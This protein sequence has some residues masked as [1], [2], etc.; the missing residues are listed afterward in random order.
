MDNRFKFFT[1]MVF[2]KNVFKTVFRKQNFIIPKPVNGVYVGASKQFKISKD[3]LNEWNELLNS[4]GNSKVIPYTYYWP[5]LM[6]WLMKKLLPELG[7]NLR[8]VLHTGQEAE[9]PQNF[10]NVVKESNVVKLKL[11]DLYPLKRNK[12]DMVTLTVV[13][14]KDG[15]VLFRAIDHTIILNMKNSDMEALK[16]SDIWGKVDVPFKN[17]SF[18]NKESKFSDSKN[19]GISEFYCKKNI[20][21]KFG[22]VS[23]ALSVTHATIL[24]AKIFRQGKV[25]LQGMCTGNIV[26]RALFHQLKEDVS[27]FEVYFTNQ[28]PFPQTV[29]VRFDETDF[30]VFDESNTMV[31]YGTRKVHQISGSIE[32]KEQKVA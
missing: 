18:R 6:D 25:F 19:C 3:Y 21:S 2:N 30:E 23:G 4:E 8:N 16:K 13:E 17:N 5:W 15:E 31:A 9:F 20:A 1:S 22:S 32:T 27:N 24:T 14:S 12:I 10:A 7:L 11:I 26:M 29:E 28:L